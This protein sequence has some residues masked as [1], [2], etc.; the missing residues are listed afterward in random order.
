[1][2]KLL[3]DRFIPTQRWP[4]NAG[5]V[6]AMTAIAAPAAKNVLVFIVRPA[7][8][9]GETIQTTAEKR[10]PKR[11]LNRRLGRPSH[12]RAAY[13]GCR[14]IDVSQSA[15]KEMLERNKPRLCTTTLVPT[16]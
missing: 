8:V 3:L 16:D 7:H 11:R 6:R 10:S 5:A 12:K 14:L 9:S 13:P 2:A 4:A 15:W 1:M